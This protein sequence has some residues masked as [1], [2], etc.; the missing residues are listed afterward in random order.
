[1][2]Q[3]PVLTQFGTSG[4]NASCGYHALL[5]SGQL[6]RQLSQGS[7]IDATALTDESA[8]KNYFYKPT[9]WDTCVAW[10]Y[11]TEKKPAGQWRQYIMQQRKNND[12][13]GEWLCGDELKSLIDTFKLL[14]AR[15]Y[16]IIENFAVIA[17]GEQ[18]FDDISSQIYTIVEDNNPFCIFFI[19]D[20]NVILN[21]SGEDVGTDGH[22]YPLVL[23]KKDDG[24]RDYYVM[25]S[26]GNKDKRDDSRVLCIIGMVEQFLAGSH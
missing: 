8:V 14:D 15:S 22:W 4:G 2:T 3:L 1:L 17:H 10:W 5:R 21:E 7:D 25:N 26:A 19:G 9:F 13:S 6:V 16:V 23:H 24:T 18:G 20:M 12:N 11:N